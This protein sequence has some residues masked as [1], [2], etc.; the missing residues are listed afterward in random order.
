MLIIH[1]CIA[2]KWFFILYN[3][4][5]FKSL[6][7]FAAFAPLFWTC[8]WAISLTSTSSDFLPPLVF[9]A[10]VRSE[11][12]HA[13]SPGTN[14]RTAVPDSG[15]STCATYRSPNTVYLSPIEGNLNGTKWTHLGNILDKTDNPVSVF[16]SFN[17]SKTWWISLIIWKINVE[18]TNWS[19][20][21]LQLIN[22]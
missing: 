10:T 9:R 7:P 4:N 11:R 21:T 8:S 16:Y 2:T 6:K 14:E 12:A 1:H 20:D 22:K 15:I 3:P 18:T 19:D 13:N 5:R 17:P